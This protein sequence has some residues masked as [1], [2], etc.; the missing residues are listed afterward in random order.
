MWGNGMRRHNQ[1]FSLVEIII[2]IA[3]M[4]VLTGVLAP[5]YLRYV[6][7]ARD[8]VAMTNAENFRKVIDLTLI[9]AGSGDLGEQAGKDAAD[10]SVQYLSSTA[11]APTKEDSHRLIYEIY[12]SFNPQG[13]DFEAIAIVRDY[14]VIQITYKDMDTN[15]VYVYYGDKTKCYGDLLKNDG[16]TAGVWNT[17]QTKEG[18][19]WV[20]WYSICE[21]KYSTQFW[22]GH[23]SN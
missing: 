1:G 19:A 16:S 14:K 7:R 21:G 11:P 13:R 12:N 5:L 22:N 9:E 4:A 15:I 8:S 20:Q 10:F 18:D 23:A 3:I 17:Y 2:V 6:Q